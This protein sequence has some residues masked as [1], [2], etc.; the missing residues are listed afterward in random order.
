MTNPAF[1]S[2]EKPQL[3]STNWKQWLKRATLCSK[4]TERTHREDNINRVISSREV[5]HMEKISVEIQ[6]ERSQ[7]RAGTGNK[8][9]DN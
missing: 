1:G 4:A 8:Q 5:P 7:Q 9:G 3:T 2:A 6:E